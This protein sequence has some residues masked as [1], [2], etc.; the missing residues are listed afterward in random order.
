MNKYEGHYFTILLLYT[1]HV[2]TTMLVS[3]NI[4]L[5]TVSTMD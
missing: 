2:M 4:N 5:L 3:F 1:I